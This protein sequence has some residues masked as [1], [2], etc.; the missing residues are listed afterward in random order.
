MNVFENTEQIYAAGI[1]SRAPFAGDEG[2]LSVIYGTHSLLP[3]STAAP[4]SPA[5]IEIS[6]VTMTTPPVT[7]R[8]CIF[9][10]HA[11]LFPEEVHRS[12]RG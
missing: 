3:T 4:Y 5:G 6:R 1:F 2:S 12:A 10:L 7:V 8:R 11:R 9:F